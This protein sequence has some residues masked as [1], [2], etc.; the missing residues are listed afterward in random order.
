MTARRA[1]PPRDLGVHGLD[2]A[3]KLSR[4]VKVARRL[5]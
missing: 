2:G 1:G 3:P 5:H 4:S